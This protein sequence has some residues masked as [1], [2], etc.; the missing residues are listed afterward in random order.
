MSQMNRDGAMQCID[1]AK[2]FIAQNKL[3]KAE[4]FLNK[5]LRMCDTAEARRLLQSL[6]KPP[7]S[8]SSQSQSS[9]SS[10][11]SSSSTLNGAPPQAAQSSAN[12]NRESTANASTSSIGSQ[13]S[14][15]MT[16]DE[17]VTMVRKILRA[18]DYYSTLG[19]SKGGDIDEKQLKKKYRKLALKLHP[20][21]N[22]SPGAEE[23]FKKLSK[24]YDCLRDKRKRQIYDQYGEDSPQMRGNNRGAQFQ[25]MTPDD[26]IRMFFGGDF[27]GGGRGGFHFHHQ[28]RQ[29]NGGGNGE[30]MQGSP[31][32]YIMQLLPIILVFLTMVLPSLMMFGGTSNSS[33]TYSSGSNLENVYFSLDHSHPFTLKRSTSLDTPYYL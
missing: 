1:K 25:Q 24:A 18:R 13:S 3:Q 28:T 16:R 5:S 2:Q 20:D 7:P 26:I 14:S 6:Q 10:A 19:L 21:R 29:R 22:K 9:S 11:S 32:A 17:E 8:Q 33:T 23:A 30:A 12:L 15:R 31:M 27:G 4:K